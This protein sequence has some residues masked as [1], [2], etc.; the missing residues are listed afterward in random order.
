M[1]LIDAHMGAIVDSNIAAENF[2]GYSK[3]EFSQLKISDL[4][5]LPPDQVLEQVKKI[6]KGLINNTIYQ[7]KTRAGLFKDIHVLA[8]PVS[9]EERKLNLAIIEDISIAKELETEL[10]KYKSIADNSPAY[11]GMASL[12]RKV[13]Y[14]NK[15]MRKEFGFSESED[16]T[17]YSNSD[18]YSAKGLEIS[19]SIANNLQENGCWYGENELQTRGGKLIPVMQSIVTIKDKTGSPLYYSMTAINIS[20]QKAAERKIIDSEENLKR[21]EIIGKLGHY[22][23]DLNSQVYTFSEGAIR[24]YGLKEQINSREEIVSLRMPEFSEIIDT[25]VNKLIQDCEPFE[26]DYQIRRKSDNQVIDIHGIAHYDKDKN[27]IFGSI[28][29]ISERKKWERKTIKLNDE[30][31]GLNARLQFLRTQERNSLAI[32]VHDKIGQQLVGLRFEIER[33]LKGVTNDDLGLQ[34][35]LGSLLANVKEMIKN[36]MAMYA[37]IKPV[38][39]QHLPLADIIHEICLKYKKQGNFR[40][41][42]YS[43]LGTAK[44]DDIIELSLLKITEGCMDNVVKYASASTVFVDFTIDEK[45]LSL[46]VRDNGVGFVDTKIQHG[47]F[48][49]LEMRELLNSIAGKIEIKSEISNGTAVNVWLPL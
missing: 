39:L 41:H 19:K 3:T 44:F 20:K 13:L 48:G 4:N 15:E 12:D 30:L 14:I 1:L 11:I 9:I 33:L 34:N 8:F 47:Q 40:L 18:F 26:L 22:T 24:L 17:K 6:Q 2:Y 7:H 21:G 36:F 42:Y 49:F 35:S 43:N 46:V 37:E 27:L 38:F 31:R 32:E 25:A 45:G 16:I 29:D 23:Y 28:K 10:N 5:I